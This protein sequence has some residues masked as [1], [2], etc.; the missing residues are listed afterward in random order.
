MSAA[1]ASNPMPLRIRFQSLAAGLSASAARFILLNNKNFMPF[2]RFY[3]K[4]ENQIFAAH[5]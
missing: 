4:F 1:G 2:K 3:I 5:R